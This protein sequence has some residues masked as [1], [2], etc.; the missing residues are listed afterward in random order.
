MGRGHARR[1]VCTGASG[2][3]RPA[4]TFRETDARERTSRLPAAS[5][6]QLGRPGG[7]DQTVRL[8]FQ[9]LR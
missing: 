7:S 1:G 3:R 4:L 9:L 6:T 8:P 5:V 2:R